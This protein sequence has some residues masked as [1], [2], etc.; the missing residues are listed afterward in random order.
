MAKFFDTFLN[1]W[2]AAVEGLSIPTRYQILANE[3]VRA[4]LTQHTET[5]ALIGS[6]SRLRFSKPLLRWLDD[7]VSA[8]PGGAYARLGGCSFVTEDRGPRKIRT[9]EQVV[10]LMMHPGNRAASLAY[11][12]FRANQPIALCIRE[13]RDM[14]PWCE[15]RIF[16]KD[17]KIMGVSQY[18]WRRAF[19]QVE[20]KLRTIVHLVSRAS[21]TIA[22][23]SHLG[24]VVADVFLTLTDRYPSW[25]LIELNPYW[26]SSD[27]CLFTWNDEGDF[28]ASLRYRA[29]NGD[30]TGALLN[31]H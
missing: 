10:K 7:T 5:R 4:F 11:R 13:W 8:F 21:T 25:A 18:H 19:P 23:R 22:A 2:P 26:T 31:F 28:D 29:A 15:F 30:L 20:D 16:I 1:R 9:G 24:T 27:S 12:C 3:D 6:A 17:R 14:P